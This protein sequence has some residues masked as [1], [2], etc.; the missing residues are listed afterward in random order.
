[1]HAITGGSFSG[2]TTTIEFL[3][4]MGHSVLPESAIWIIDSLNDLYGVEKQISW[5]TKNM[6]EFQRL[7]AIADRLRLQIALGRGKNASIFWDRGVQDGLAYCKIRKVKPPLELVALS[8]E[9][10]YKKVFV[11]DTLTKFD[12]R[13]GTGRQSNRKLSVEIGAML[14][15]VYQKYADE[16]IVVPEMPVRKRIDFILSH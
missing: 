8:K 16:V 14:V 12:M 2:K 10:Y 7:V 13:R 15:Q 11:L 4:D 9:V 1:M 3:R 6:R 5:R